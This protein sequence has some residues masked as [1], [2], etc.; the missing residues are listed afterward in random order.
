MTHLGSKKMREGIKAVMRTRNP[1][2]SI[3]WDI[4]TVEATPKACILM[5]SQT[6]ARGMVL[7]ELW[8]WR[9]RCSEFRYRNFLIIPL[10]SIKSHYHIVSKQETETGG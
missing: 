4:A 7:S 10:N 5:N 2:A 3:V 8:H 6:L 9:K 1:M